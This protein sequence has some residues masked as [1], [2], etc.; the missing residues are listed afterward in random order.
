MNLLKCGA[1]TRRLQILIL[2][3]LLVSGTVHGGWLE[4]V[5]QIRPAPP[6]KLV[7]IED[8][9]HDLSELKGRVVLVNFWTTW[10]PPCI[11]EMPSLVRLKEQIQPFDLVILTVNVQEKKGRVSTIASRLK[12][13][14]PVLLDSE[15]EVGD[16]WEVKV[17]PSTFL[18]DAKGRLRYRAIGPV[19]WDSDDVTSTIRRLLKE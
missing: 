3:T 12:L 11:E 14:F 13:P 17:F 16:A 2:I 8:T 4:A 9:V 18:V 10:C 7:D 5:E 1:Y 19:E 6:L 15:R